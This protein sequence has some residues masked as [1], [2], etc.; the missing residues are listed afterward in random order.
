[1]KASKMWVL[2][3]HFNTGIPEFF[4]WFKPHPKIINIEYLL[5]ND[6]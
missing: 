5:Q 4:N 3:M 1:M 6:R 2:H